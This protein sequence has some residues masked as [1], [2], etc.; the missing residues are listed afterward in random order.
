METNATRRVAL[1]SHTGS[2]IPL[3]AAR[4]L[5]IALVPDAVLFGEREYLNFY[6]IDCRDFYRMMAESRELPTSSHPSIGHFLD[7]FEA[8]ADA[9][10]VLCI[11]C[12][13]KMSGTYE[14][15]CMAKRLIEEQGYAPELFI[16]DSNQVS[17]GLN[18]MLREA[19]RL[20][21][22]GLDARAIMDALT[23]YQT[24]IGNYETCKTLKNLRKSGRAGAVKTAAAEVL[25]IKPFLQFK[26]GLVSDIA[27]ARSFD[28][29]MDML[30]Q[31]YCAEAE[32]RDL[33]IICHAENLPDAEALRDRI[34]TAFPQARL[35]IEY[36]SSVIGIHTGIGCIG[37]VF[38]RRKQP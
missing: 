22:R 7:A 35:C 24:E 30:F 29:A 2:D 26:D 4:E 6:E 20:R 16:Y 37:L 9:E 34:L 11:T 28:R 1:I 25:G 18:L 21:D 15:A 32:P 5:G 27:I 17:H 13:G 10:Q 31:K 8:A 23:V 36:V 12:T 33:A 38:H 14:T 3:D 19:A